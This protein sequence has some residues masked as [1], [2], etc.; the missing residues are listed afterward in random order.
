MRDEV[1]RLRAEKEEVTSERDRAVAEKDR[2]VKEMAAE[3]DQAVAEKEEMAAE[4]D[5]AVKEVANERD[6]AV[7]EKKEIAAERDKLAEENH[8]LKQPVV[9]RQ[10]P[11]I[12]VSSRPKSAGP[13]SAVFLSKPAASQALRKR[14]LPP[15]PLK[16][17]H[18]GSTIGGYTPI[19]TYSSC[20][21]D[22]CS[23]TSYSSGTFWA[24]RQGN[25]CLLKKG[26]SWV[27][28][29]IPFLYMLLIL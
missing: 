25:Q 20:S 13:G 15:T 7:A 29:V 21:M 23:D 27:L 18:T 19:G 3:R 24:E 26:I 1:R 22:A 11:P 9:P 12:P 4:R 28:A 5:R 10:R 6:L 17:S 2:A 8:L 14:M 16:V